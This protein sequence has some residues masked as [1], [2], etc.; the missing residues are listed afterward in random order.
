MAP[1][2]PGVAE[3]LWEKMLTNQVSLSVVQHCTMEGMMGLLR[4]QGN[5]EG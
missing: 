5:A 1:S 3:H 2:G 4:L